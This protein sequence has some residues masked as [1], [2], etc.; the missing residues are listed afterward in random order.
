MWD[1]VKK[2]F[3]DILFWFKDDIDYDILD[4][5]YNQGQGPIIKEN[6]VDLEKVNI[7]LKK[8]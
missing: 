4:S 6:Q 3:K 2:H 8:D 1:K 7:T 5:N